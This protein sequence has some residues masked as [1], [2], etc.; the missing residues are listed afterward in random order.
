MFKLRVVGVVKGKRVIKG[1]SKAR[2]V[3]RKGAIKGKGR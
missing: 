3:K 2:A 1:W